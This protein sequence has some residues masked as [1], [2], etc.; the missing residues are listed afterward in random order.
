[1]TSSERGTVSLEGV[2][3]S[4]LILTGSTAAVQ[5]LGIVRELFIAAHA[6][7]STELDALLIAMAL[8]MGLAGII[9][10]GVRIALVQGYLEARTTT[11]QADA[12]RLAGTVLVIVGIVGM[13]AWAGLELL[14]G[15]AIAIVGPG[16][17]EASRQTATDFLHLLAPLVFVAAVTAVIYA[18]L[19]A[20]ERFGT[21]AVAGF[22]GIAT[23]LLVLV[24]L[25]DSFGLWSLAIGNLVGPIVGLAILVGAAIGRSLMPAP[26]PHRDPRLRTMA[27]HAGPLTV[28]FAILQINVIGDRAIASLIGPGAVSTLRYADVLV[29]T[30]VGA[31]GPAWGS[32]IYPAL[33]RSSLHGMASTLASS[34]TR[35]LTWVLALF[36]PVAILTVAVAPLAVTVAYGRGAFTADDI[37][38]TASAVAAFAPLIVTI[39]L[40]PVLT[41]AANAR[42]RGVLLLA[43][44]TL[45]VAVNISMDVVLGRLI[46]VTGIALASSLAESIVVVFFMIR[47]ARSDDAFRLGP[48]A[49]TLVRAI[50]ASLPV[51]AIIAAFTWTG[52]FP[53]ET[54][55][56]L[57]ALGL[58]GVV[59]ILGY[60]SIASRVGLDEPLDIVR[61]TGA[62]VRRRL[63]TGG[64]A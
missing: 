44:A 43:G 26:I 47:F 20:E 50:V 21:L 60:I 45:N 40:V 13:V 17:S 42:R 63:S 4:A 25:W 48:L 23:T 41:G 64:V 61:R 18:I 35:A 29:R 57:V 27:D 56:A 32:A 49:A 14:S 1:V 2:A 22:A 3:R 5:V 31:I 53:R 46:G 15:P 33:V 28:G 59:G 52:T 12:R 9:S 10:G 51:A 38:A 39:M 62:V 55:T 58:S 16:L 34:T 24:T 7:I 11:G 54:A 6:G 36:V 30:P 8:P 37:I 19:Q